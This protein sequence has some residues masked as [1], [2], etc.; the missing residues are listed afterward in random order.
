MDP[1]ITTAL[2]GAVATIVAALIGA[3]AVRRKCAVKVKT[4]F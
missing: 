2:I 3:Q 4:E 1:T